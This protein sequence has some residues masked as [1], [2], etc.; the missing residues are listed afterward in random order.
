VAMAGAVVAGAV[1]F[2]VL[3]RGPARGPGSEQ[4]ARP[5]HP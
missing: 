3:W 5:S 1:V 2:A 4:A